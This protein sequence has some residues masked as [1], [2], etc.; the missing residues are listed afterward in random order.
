[1]KMLGHDI[2]LVT[3]N[4]RAALRLRS[5]LIK[6]LLLCRGGDSCACTTGAEGCEKEE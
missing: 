3:P 4:N 1:M 2:D 6:L 5:R